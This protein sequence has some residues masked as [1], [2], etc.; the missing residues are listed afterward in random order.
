VIGGRWAISRSARTKWENLNPNLG[1]DVSGLFFADLAHDNIADVI[2]LETQFLPN[3]DTLKFTWWASD[4]GTQGWRKLRRYSFRASA[5]LKL[6]RMFAGAGRFGAAPGGAVLLAG[7]DRIG[8]FYGESE[9]QVGASPNWTS[10][11]N[12]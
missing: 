12:Y 4:N 2:R 8:R 6:P 5:V 1:D 3:Q 11:Y 9:V 10:L 7:P